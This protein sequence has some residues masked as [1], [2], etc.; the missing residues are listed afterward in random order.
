MASRSPINPYA[1]EILETVLVEDTLNQKYAIG[2][3]VIQMV[4]QPDGRVM[5]LLEDSSHASAN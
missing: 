2:W 5:L 1:V 3:K 4:A